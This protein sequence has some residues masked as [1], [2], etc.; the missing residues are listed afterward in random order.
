MIL[1]RRRVKFYAGKLNYKFKEN[2]ELYVGMKP[3]DKVRQ[4]VHIFEVNKF[5]KSLRLFTSEKVLNKSEA[6]VLL[7]RILSINESTSNPSWSSVM[8][9]LF[10]LFAEFSLS[11]LSSTTLRDLDSRDKWQLVIN[12]YEKYLTKLKELKAYDTALICRKNLEQLDISGYSELVLDGAFLPLTPVLQVIIDKFRAQDKPITA[13]LPFDLENPENPALRAIQ[14]V[15]ENFVSTTAW[16]S[17]QTIFTDSFFI[18]RLPKLIFQNEK[19]T[20]LDSSF[21]IL[22]FNTVE[23]ELQFIMQKIYSL[24]K[25]KGI[26]PRQIVLVTP[27]A[28][29]IRPLLREISEQHNLR[30]H[31]PK[32]PL[33]HL[34][35][36]RAIKHL[37][38]LRVDIRKEADT[39]FTSKL[40]RVFLNDSILSH[41]S[42]LLEAF[43]R[44][45]CF[46]ED[47]LSIHDFTNKISDLSTAKGLLE[48]KYQQHPLQTVTISQLDELCSILQFLDHIS[49]SL[50]SAP[51][52]RLSDHTKNLISLLKNDK[53]FREMDDEIWDR[54]LSINE[55]ASGQRNLPITGAEFGTRVSSLFYESEEFEPGEQPIEDGRDIYLEKEI[56]VTGPNNVE[57]QKY[58]YV[59]LCRFTQDIYPEPKHYTWL[60]TKQVEHELL[61]RTTAFC[62]DNTR[63]LDQFYLDRGLYHIYL[64]LCAPKTQLTISY[65][66]M[67]NGQPLTPAHYLHD[68]AR[69]F[70]IEEGNRLEN[71]KEDSL[72]QLLERHN[73]LKSPSRYIP[74]QDEPARHIIPSPL[75][76]RNFTAEDIA[77]FKY[78]PRRFYYQNRNV[79]EYVYSQLFHL[80]SYA[81]SCLYEK[82]IELFVQEESFPVTES[83][84]TKKQFNR[85]LSVIIERR[86]EAEQIVRPLFPIGNR[87]WQNIKVETDFFLQSLLQRIF[88][89]KL[90]RDYRKAGN[91]MV[92]IHMVINKQD[93][94]ITI[95][96]FKFSSIR[97]LEVQYIGLESH[98]YSIS[99]RK[100]I[101]SFS[102]SDHEEK[103]TMEEIKQW[104][105]NFKREFKYRTE[106]VMET[107]G[108]VIEGV[109]SGTFHKKTGGHCMYCSFNKI[110]R[111]R[112]VDRC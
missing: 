91:S 42:N 81:T 53:H 67:D 50:I 98:R 40:M 11:G 100:D 92:K 72:E 54:I 7:E 95:G 109:S 97:E 82:A 71:K 59:F 46:F 45:E 112:E 28:M 68:I 17:I 84:D 1:F 44:I 30:V 62:P 8:L 4:F 101:L 20:H 80:M 69:V 16:V 73:I 83:L 49:S 37:F 47:C 89:G 12:I 93:D 108:Q 88:D 78:C 86:A 51:A 2:P 5:V 60:K 19:P 21:S 39:Y 85:L 48:D 15:Y 18:N 102:T 9:E 26:E 63:E 94:I 105:F 79:D 22:R 38:D 24:I 111:E 74:T 77:I 58:D 56:L 75:T 57:F 41:S 66:K 14:R 107:L 64:T 99:N 106:G 25:Y 43:E 34:N 33:L 23:E 31:L 96:D 36:G 70:G 13:L 90:L 32:R 61:K 55:T 76:E 10:E 103:D 27:G 6:T 52:A 65:A 104:Y 110:C 3:E 29:E 87:L 35:Q